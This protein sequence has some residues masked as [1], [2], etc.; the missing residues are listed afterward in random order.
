M[1]TCRYEYRTTAAIMPCLGAAVPCLDAAV[2]IDGR[3]AYGEVRPH[4][5]E[6]VRSAVLALSETWPTRPD[7]QPST[8]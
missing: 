8:P 4:D 3:N 1:G 6:F 7:E 5:D 2:L